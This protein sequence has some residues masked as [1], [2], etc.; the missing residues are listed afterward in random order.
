MIRCCYH[1][2]SDFLSSDDVLFCS[3]NH[4]TNI[5]STYLNHT[6]NHT[7]T[8]LQLDTS[9]VA[10]KHHEIFVSV[11]NDK[12]NFVIIVFILII[13]F[14]L[15][16]IIS[17]SSNSCLHGFLCS[18][19]FVIVNGGGIVSKLTT[20]RFYEAIHTIILENEI[21]HEEPMLVNLLNGCSWELKPC[22]F[23]SCSQG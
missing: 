7:V 18:G 20:L 13:V 10:F 16:I 21:E 23:H 1:S 9:S 8:P 11:L 2:D 14:V 12:S 6:S 17:S 19:L 22:L 15:T 3:T 5:Y 4:N